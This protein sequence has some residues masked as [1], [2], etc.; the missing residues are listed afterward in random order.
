MRKFIP[1]GIKIKIHLLRRFVRDIFNGYTFKYAKRQETN[2]DFP[3]THKISQELKPNNAKKHNLLIAIAAIESVIIQPNELFSFWK[4]VGNP[5][6]KKGFMESRSLINGKIQ[7]SVGGGLCQLSGLIY[8][9]SLFANLEIIERHNHSKDIYTEETRF[10]PLGSDATVAYGYKDLRIKNN[11][12]TPIRFTFFVTENELIIDLKHK[13]TIEKK[14]IEFHKESINEHEIKV[15]TLVNK[16][17]KHESIYKKNT[18]TNF[19]NSE[20]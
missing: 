18:A 2:I 8:Y 15:T 16:E 3:F 10:T 11:L 1:T 13:E 4:T 19:H 14:T 12:Q 17:I 6:R 5:T 7:P 9:A 20:H